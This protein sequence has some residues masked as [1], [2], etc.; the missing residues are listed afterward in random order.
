MC[1]SVSLYLYLLAVLIIAT[2]QGSLLS[3]CVS[4]HGTIT[5][6]INDGQL[7]VVDRWLL[8]ALGVFDVSGCTWFV[9]RSSILKPSTESSSGSG[10]CF[11]SCLGVVVLCLCSRPA[12][13]TSE[14]KH[15]HTLLQAHTEPTVRTNKDGPPK[16]C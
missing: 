14:P 9:E 16:A 5:V 4:V 8:S 11:Y 15:T 1:A 13:S 10:Y 12:A 7:V 3:L 6:S 2:K